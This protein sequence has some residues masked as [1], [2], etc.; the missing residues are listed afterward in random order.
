[1]E[2]F[3]EALPYSLDHYIK[4]QTACEILNQLYK[5]I[6]RE[7]N[8]A[9]YGCYA[10]YYMIR[11]NKDSCQLGFTADC[12][13][14]P[15][16]CDSVLTL[17]K[18]IFNDMT[19]NIDETIFRNAKE[20]LLKSYDELVK[21]ANG[22]WLDTMWRKENTGIDFYTDRRKLIEQLTPNELL[23][24]MKVFQAH[25]HHSETLMQPE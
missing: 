13:M 11:D 1:M 12:E 17:M 22:F 15:E 5:D 9:T 6:I 21:T 2:W 8:S 19:K 10:G 23:S 16:M 25:A 7:E 14:K 18:S 4:A 3:T 24:F 20:S